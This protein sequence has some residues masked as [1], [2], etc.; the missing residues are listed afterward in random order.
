MLHGVG[1]HSSM[2]FRRIQ[3]Q[4]EK[5]KVSDIVL[6]VNPQAFEKMVSISNAVGIE[7]ADPLLCRS[8]DF[9]CVSLAEFYSSAMSNRI[10]R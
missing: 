2:R 9:L 8:D 5:F 4:T 1:C 7:L 3:H 10:N 6:L